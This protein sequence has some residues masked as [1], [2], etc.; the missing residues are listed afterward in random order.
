MQ[1]AIFDCIVYKQGTDKVFGYNNV[2]LSYGPNVKAQALAE[3]VEE[4]V[5]R[6]Y[7]VPVHV[8]IVNMMKL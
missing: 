6:K 3:N 4:T 5:R 2:T 1:E 8:R 7:D